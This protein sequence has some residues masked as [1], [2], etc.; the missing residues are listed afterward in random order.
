[1]LAHIACCSLSPTPMSKPSTVY[2]VQHKPNSGD[3]HSTPP[4]MSQVSPRVPRMDMPAAM[5][6]DAT[7]ESQLDALLDAI[8][9]NQDGM[10]VA[11]AAQWVLFRTC[12]LR[13]WCVPQLLARRSS[14]RRRQAPGHSEEGEEP[15]THHLCRRC[16][17]GAWQ[18]PRPGHCLCR[19][20]SQQGS[21]GRRPPTAR[22]QR[23]RHHHSH[24]QVRC[25]GGRLQPCRGHSVHGRHGCHR[26]ER[27]GV[28]TS[29][30]RL[31]NRL[32]QHRYHDRVPCARLQD[33]HP[34]WLPQR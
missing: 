9:V 11:S 6:A 27:C 19:Q 26:R 23:Q 31:G 2:V 8:D 16:R 15:Q 34:P 20:R 29:H 12:S 21:E 33:H 1:M 17:R 5:A 13:C 10:Y 32:G 22:H 28:L 7:P 25:V 3:L 24:S 30:R 18:C 14:H 4:S